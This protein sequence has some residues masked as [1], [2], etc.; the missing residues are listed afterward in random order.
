MGWVAVLE[1]NNVLAM[2]A[3]AWE[4]LLVVPRRVLAYKIRLESTA[5]QLPGGQAEGVRWQ[6]DAVGLEREM[7]EVAWEAGGL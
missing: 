3:W 7:V 1:G 5:S 6:N 4:Q 2:G